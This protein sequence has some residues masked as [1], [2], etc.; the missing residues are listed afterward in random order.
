M[1]PYTKV[2]L[3]LLLFTAAALGSSAD[4]KE[5]NNTVPSCEKL[6]SAM[7]TEL[8]V[9]KSECDCSR[10]KKRFQEDCLK[11][12]VNNDH[13]KEASKKFTVAARKWRK[14]CKGKEREKEEKEEEKGLFQVWI[15]MLKN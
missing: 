7:K 9:K 8:R 13:C 10:L 4:N 1:V 15:D 12:R 2:V 5:E 6:K 11:R 14:H 3:L